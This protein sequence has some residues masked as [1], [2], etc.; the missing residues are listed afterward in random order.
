MGR[1]K[2]RN[3][4]R[5]YDAAKVTVGAVE[6]VQGTRER[7]NRFL[8]PLALSLGLV[9]CVGLVGVLALYLIPPEHWPAILDPNAW[10]I[11]ATI[12]I[13][14][15]SLIGWGCMQEGLGEMRDFVGH[16]LGGWLFVLL[17]L[18]CGGFMLCAANQ[19]VNLRTLPLNPWSELI[20]R[21][22]PPLVMTCAV[23]SFMVVK[24]D[25]RQEGRVKRSVWWS[26]V[27]FPYLLLVG[28][29]VFGI[30]SPILKD[31][32]GPTMRELGSSAVV[33][34]IVIA[35]FVTAGGD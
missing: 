1:R 13:V 22:Y 34:Q 21:F 24:T 14:A 4:S 20:V 31:S 26:L 33:L 5:L 30:E 2:R 12:A 6:V 3:S 29:L 28:Y 23:I 25:V 32:L 18:I 11:Y 17:P 7:L 15:A 8:L 19:W 10:S 9:G 27:L 35:Y 16:R